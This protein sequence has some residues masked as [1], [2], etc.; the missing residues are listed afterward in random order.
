MWMR[1]I[2]KAICYLEKFSFFNSI[3]YFCSIG[4]LGENGRGVCEHTKVD[5]ADIDILMGTFT[6][7]FGSVGGYVAADEETISYLRATSYGS[8]YGTAMSPPCAQ[9]ALQALRVIMGEDGTDE[10]RETEA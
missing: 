1:R 2:G 5:P 3:D 7:A 10:G 6:K 9:Q 4:A 8:V